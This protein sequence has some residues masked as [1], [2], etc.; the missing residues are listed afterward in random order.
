MTHKRHATIVWKVFSSLFLLTT[1]L[2]IFSCGKDEFVLPGA[3]LVNT[4]NNYYARGRFTQAS[5]TYRKFI[6]EN[7]DSPFRKKAILGLADS[8]YKD[9][10]YFE[11]A[12][13]YERFAELYPLDNLTSRAL[14]YMSMCYFKNSSTADRDQTQTN[15]AIESF[16]K[17]LA[18]YPN[19]N[20]APIAKKLRDEKISVR[21]GA[22]LE[23]ARFYHRINKSQS[24]IGR[25][26]EYLAFYPGSKQEPE[27]MFLL[28]ECY[29][30]EQSYKIAA[31]IFAAI[32][33]TYPQSAYAKK[34]ADLSERI[35]IKK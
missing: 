6:D 15:K 16:D 23:V 24:A 35:T 12:L 21:A 4:A 8:L 26:K 30:R 33:K 10:L 32:I 7:P 25:L 9:K 18:T 17:F 1:L 27:A 31:R 5:D 11:A 34:A 14:F 2:A 20:L 3:G 29:Y 13:Y 22:A 19:H 28:G